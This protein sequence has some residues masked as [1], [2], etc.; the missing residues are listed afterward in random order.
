MV[1]TAVKAEICELEEEVRVGCSRR[2]RKELTGVV[3][4]V[5]GRRKFLVRY[6]NGRKKNLSS[7]Q[8]TVVLVDNILVEEEPLVST[9]SEIPE[10]QVEKQ[11]G[12]Y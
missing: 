12:Y 5:L 3:Q 4:G 10:D 1:G 2:M 8:L 7:N 6:H 11:R 9:I